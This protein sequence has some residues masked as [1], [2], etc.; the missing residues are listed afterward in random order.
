MPFLPSGIFAYTTVMYSKPTTKRFAIALEKGVM[1]IA[2]G[3]ETQCKIETLSNADFTVNDFTNSD[4]S[5]EL[6]EW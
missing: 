2:S 4:D 6:I 3:V 1:Q 5:P